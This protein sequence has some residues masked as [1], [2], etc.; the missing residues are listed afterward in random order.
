MI[1]QDKVLFYLMILLRPGTMLTYDVL[2]PGH[3]DEAYWPHA[4]PFSSAC[5]HVM[6]TCSFRDAS[7][8]VAPMAGPDSVPWS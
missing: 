3:A 7:L 2:I 1:M 4:A 5:K 6:Q 8:I